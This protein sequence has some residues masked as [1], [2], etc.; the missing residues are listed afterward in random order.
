MVSVILGVACFTYG[1][2]KTWPNEPDRAIPA[3]DWGFDAMSGS[4]WTGGGS[5]LSIISD[6]TAPLSAPNVAQYKYSTGF[7]AGV[8]PGAFNHSLNNMTELFIG[9]WWKPSSPWQSEINSSVNK[10]MYL[11][12]LAGNVEQWIPEMFGRTGGPYEARMV[13]QTTA[14]N[15][16]LG[17][18]YGDVGGTWMLRGNISNPDIAVG[19]WH[20]WEIYIK[21][22]TNPSAK[23]GTLIWWL[24]GQLVGLFQN[25]NT[26]LQAWNKIAVDPTWGGM[27]STKTQTDYFW[28]DHIHFSAP[29]GI[30]IPLAI[31]TGTLGSGAKGKPYSATLSATGGTPPYTWTVASGSLPAGLALSGNVISGTLT[32]CGRSNFAL[33]VTDKSVPPKSVTKDYSI[34]VSGSCTAISGLEQSTSTQSDFSIQVKS[35]EMR[36]VLPQAGESGY[37]LSIFNLAGKKVHVQNSEAQAQGIVRTGMDLKNGVYIAELEQGGKHFYSRFLVS[38]GL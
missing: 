23:N 26:P 19:Q 35:G 2:T 28:F 5:G 3:L 38:K 17:S 1:Q 36:F 20:R 25:V 9:F 21:N 31:L 10:I 7:T 18:G 6:P 24:D 12:A 27:N 22:S 29:N 16:Q 14:D 4:G 33:K 8:A 15:S 30:A 34:V 37:R 11:Q 13:L 32:G